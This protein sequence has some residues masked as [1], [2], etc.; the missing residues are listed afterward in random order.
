MFRSSCKALNNSWCTVIPGKLAA[1]YDWFLLP[2]SLYAAR[3]T[4]RL[5]SGFSRSISTV[6]VFPILFLTDHKAQGLVTAFISGDCKAIWVTTEFSGQVS[7]MFTGPYLCTRLV[8]CRT[9]SLSALVTQE[10]NMPKTPTTPTRHRNYDAAYKL[11]A[12]HLAMVR[13]NRA[14]AVDLDI[15]ESMIRRWRK[16]EDL[17][18][19]CKN[20]RKKF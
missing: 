3:M 16:Q 4:R 2:I 20:T 1:A 19:V 5:F 7:F 18:A 10:W 6:R 15:N 12:I 8:S 9:H 17:L 14:A 11:K 13:G